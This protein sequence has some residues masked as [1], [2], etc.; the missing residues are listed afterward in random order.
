MRALPG[1][2]PA[3]ARAASTGMFVVPCSSFEGPMTDVLSITGSGRFEA[4]ELPQ[5]ADHLDS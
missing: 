3:T 1:V 5:L 4:G 2:V